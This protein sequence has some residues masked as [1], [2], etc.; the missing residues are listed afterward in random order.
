M[1]TYI[2]TSNTF[3][4][5]T[6][7]VQYSKY[8]S[9]IRLDLGSGTFPFEYTTDQKGGTFFFYVPKVDRTF[10]KPI[11]IPTIDIYTEEIN[12]PECD[13]SGITIFVPPCDI[14]YGIVEVPVC[15]I[16]YNITN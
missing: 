1:I 16:E 6:I 12:V 13:L 2:F 3:K 15:D 10:P 14:D 8:D 9:T 11:D 4:G 7:D 5:E